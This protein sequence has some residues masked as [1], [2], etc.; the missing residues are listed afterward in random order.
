MALCKYEAKRGSQNFYHLPC[1]KFD[2]GSHFDAEILELLALHLQARS[3]GFLQLV[4]Y[5]R[6]FGAKRFLAIIE[7]KFI[8]AIAILAVLLYFGLTFLKDIFNANF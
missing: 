1:D 2:P 6:A 8:A 4:L 5:I 3:G 7:P